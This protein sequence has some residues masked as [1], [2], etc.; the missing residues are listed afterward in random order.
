[1]FAMKK[2]NQ[3]KHHSLAMG[4]LLMLLN[5]SVAQATTLETIVVGGKS[6]DKG[7]AGKDEIFT[8]DQ[9]TEYK[10]KKEIETFHGQSVSDLFSGI[11]GVYSG[12]ARN[13]ELLTPLFV[14]HG[15]KVGYQFLL[16]IQNNL[17]RFGV[18]MR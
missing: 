14:A 12:D 1:M 2:S 3:L 7:Q 15:D 16:M 11:T 6:G 17:L 13:G 4:L 8:K 9:V 5:L 18:V 10:S